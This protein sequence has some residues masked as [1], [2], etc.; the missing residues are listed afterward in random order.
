MN[1]VIFASHLD[2]FSVNETLDRLGIEFRTLFGCWK[3]I[4]EESYMVDHQDYYRF[5][6]RSILVRGQE[7]V[8]V[9][10]G[11]G[12]ERSLAFIDKEVGPRDYIGIFGSCSWDVSKE[13]NF[14]LDP[15]TGITYT[16]NVDKNMLGDNRAVDLWDARLKHEI[17]LNAWDWRR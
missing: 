13:K 11:P 9:I 10:E 17:D 1:F 16:C 6:R 12:D 2:R 3:G 4:P 7:S 14:T 8:L 5:I 15:I